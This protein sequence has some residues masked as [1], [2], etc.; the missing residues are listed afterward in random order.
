MY[1]N[2]QY[3]RINTAAFFKIKNINLASNCTTPNF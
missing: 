3:L 2:L 1:K